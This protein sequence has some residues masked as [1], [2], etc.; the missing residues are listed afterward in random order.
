MQTHCA[1]PAAAACIRGDG[2]H[3]GL[4]GRVTFTPCSRGVLV[5]ADIS[6]LP[7]SETGFFALHI[8]EGPDC[9]GEGFPNTSG[10]YNP[11]GKPHPQ[12]AGDLPPLVSCGGRAWL[13]VL[14]NR[15]R[16]GEIIG[17]TVV[18]HS[19]PDDFRTQPSGGAGS[20]IACGVI[21]CT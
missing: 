12:H 7:D 20:K 15:F 14:T 13:S 18:I 2:E 16:L 11:E 1:P 4:R 6:G 9:C 19:H 10:H 17:R 5:T 3:P 8:H 21:R